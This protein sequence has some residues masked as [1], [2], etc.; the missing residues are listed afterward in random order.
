M[1]K[2]NTP[3]P[4]QTAHLSNPTII[5]VPKTALDAD[6]LVHDE[7]VQAE[8][9]EIV[10]GKSIDADDVVHEQPET[11]SPDTEVV[12]DVDDVIHHKNDGLEI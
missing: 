4:Q 6:E 1:E 11:I 2:K 10:E 7:N 3:P 12:A 5:P 9:S 8:L